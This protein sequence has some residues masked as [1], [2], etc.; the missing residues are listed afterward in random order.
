M[1]EKVFFGRKILITAGPTREAIDP[2]RYISNHSTGKMGYAI[3]TELLEQGAEVILIS[4]PVFITLK[5][6]NLELISV[7][8]ASEMYQAC[9]RFFEIAD[10]AIFTAAVADYRPSKI[11]DQKIKK[12]DT[13]FTIAMTKNI[14]IAYEFGKIKTRKQLSIG[15]ALETN[16]EQFHAMEKLN[17]KNFDMVIL[18]SMNDAKATFGFDTNK[19][20]IYKADFSCTYYPLKNKNEVAADIIFEAG[21]LLAIKELHEIE[22][23]T[24]GYETMYQ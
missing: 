15:F 8:T 12:S 2:V 20:S 22:E 9:C 17:K 4:G 13:C 5:H 6:P 10:V 24:R 7:T 23:M 11:A 18:N 1:S 3:A 16:N 19:I 14:D 21:T